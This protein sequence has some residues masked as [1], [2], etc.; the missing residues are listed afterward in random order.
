MAGAQVDCESQVFKPG[1]IDLLQ[2]RLHNDI[3]EAMPMTILGRNYN[4]LLLMPT[5]T[6]EATVMR[7]RHHQP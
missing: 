1:R 6:V 3:A 5:V 7:L 2:A 4:M